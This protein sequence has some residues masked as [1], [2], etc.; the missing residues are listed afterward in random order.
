MYEEL[1]IKLYEKESL[2]KSFLLFF[3]VI[4]LFLSFIFY[5]YYKIEREHLREYIFLEMKNYSFFFDDD[6]FDIDIVS[7]E[8][9]SKLYELYMDEKQLFIFSPLTGEGEDTL[10]KIYYDKKKYKNTLAE[11]KTSI[12]WQ[13]GFLTFIAILIS[14]LFSIYS[15]DPM[16]KSLKVLEEFIKDIIHDLNTPI[17]SILINLKMLNSQTLEAKSIA[18]SAKTISMLHHN[19]DSYLKDIQFKKEKFHLKEVLD[20]QVEYF[21]S[22]Y[23]YLD[24]DIKIDDRVILSDRNSFSRI[25]YNLLSN[26]CKYN[27]SDGY[28]TIKT[29]NNSIYIKNS[30]HGIKN[31]SKIFDRFYKES[32]RGLGIGLHI[33]AKLCDELKIEKKLEVKDKEVKIELVL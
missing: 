22:I 6:K 7:K 28:I 26:A 2:L 24:W 31:P 11:I 3:I 12:F 27:K 4:L 19:L 25:I 23:N 1:V 32:D 21:S 15:L 20:E 16:R 18:Q 9:D 30:S 13:F 10:L 14:L 5:N 33:V 29:E 17:T 8:A